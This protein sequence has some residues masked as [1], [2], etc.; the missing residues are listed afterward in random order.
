MKNL[1][2]MISTK[3]ASYLAD[4]FNWNIV[5][6]KKYNHYIEMVTDEVISKKLEELISMHLDFCKTIVK[7]LESGRKNEG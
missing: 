4:M 7:L 3:D 5:T 1:P 6:A 2:K